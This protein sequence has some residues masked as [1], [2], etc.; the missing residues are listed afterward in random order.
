MEGIASVSF[1]AS[2]DQ[3]LKKLEA[4]RI[5][6]HYGR[7]KPVDFARMIAKISFSMAVA[8]GALA[9]IKEQSS[10]VLPA[11]LG[12]AEDIGWWVGTITEPISQHEDHLHRVLIHEDK[13]RGL[14]LGD[15]QLFSDSQ[16]PR[17]GVI[18]GELRR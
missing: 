16:T 3:I 8:V 15:V 7:D 1:G 2:P 17:Y 6:F 4:D 12:E 13:Q 18:L 5:S 14:L 9:Q 11:L 10:P